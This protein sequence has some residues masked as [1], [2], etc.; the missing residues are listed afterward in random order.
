MHV[1]IIN[2]ISIDLISGHGG[3]V[4]AVQTDGGR[5]NYRF[6]GVGDVSVCMTYAPVVRTSVLRAAGPSEGVNVCADFVGHNESQMCVTRLKD[7]E[8][9][10]VRQRGYNLWGSA[11]WR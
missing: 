6:T 11:Q 5:E 9:R 1:P 2:H 8:G 4:A 10:E 7:W 3:G